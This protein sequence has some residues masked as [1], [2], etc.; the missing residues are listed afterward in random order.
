MGAIIIYL[1]IFFGY[2]L[3][4]SSS[5]PCSLFLSYNGLGTQIRGQCAAAQP[6]Y[7]PLIQSKSN[8]TTS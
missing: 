2:A 4:R 5:M 3:E 1:I 6:S 7:K 8:E